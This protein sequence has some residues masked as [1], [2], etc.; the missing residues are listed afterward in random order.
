MPSFANW[1][2]EAI[3]PAYEDSRTLTGRT[4][5]VD[6][7]TDIF[8]FG[9]VLYEMLTGKRCFDGD[10]VSDILSAVLRVEPDWTRLP[11]G[12][13]SNVRNLLRLC[14]EK[15]AKNRRSDAT[16]VR[17]DIELALK[18]PTVTE[19]GSTPLLGRSSKAGWI[20]ATVVALALLSL[21]AVHFQEKPPAEPPE[22]RVDIT[23]P[24]TFL[25]LQF[26]LSP[27]GRSIVFVASGD[28]A[29]RLWL[30]RLDYA[31]AQALT[32][33]EGGQ[34]PFWS[35][36]GKSIAFFADAKLKRV[37]LAGGAPTVLTDA[38]P[39][40]G[41][42]NADG[43]ILFRTTLAPAISRINAGSGG[44]PATVTQVQG[45]GNLRSPHFL[46]DGKHF[47]F[48]V[49]AVANV[50]GLYLG[51]L[52]GGVPKRLG[53]A[54]SP[55]VPLPP[56]RILYIQQGKLL[57]RRL[58]L[59]RGELIGDPETV[60]D[61]VGT[62]GNNIGGFSV[63]ADGR[64]AY[65]SG[66]SGSSQLTWLDRSGK[67][68]GKPLDPDTNS[69]VAA[70][71]SPDGRRVAVDR[72]VQSNRDV[73]LIDLLRGGMT[74]FTFDAATD[75]YPVWSAD[76]IQIAFESSRKGNFDIYIKPS[77]G[78]GLEQPL[79]EAPGSQW[80]NDF[81]KDGKFLLYFDAS[82]SG[83]LMVLP[84][85]GAN[86]GPAGRSNQDSTGNERKPIPVATTTFVERT[87]A[88]SPDGRWVAYDTNESGKFEVVVQAF[89][90][91]NGKWQVSTGGG[92]Y[93]RWRADGKEL[94]FVADGKLMAAA[95]HVSGTSIDA[96]T[97]TPLFPLRINNSATGRQQ[98]AVSRDGRFLVNQ[99]TE[100][101]TVTPIT[102]IL[103]W[104]PK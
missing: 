3:N 55:A 58:D 17:L 98:Y 25:A 15:N 70:E 104:R 19:S 100:A 6:K 60:A 82:N 67:P 21:A 68:A 47:L 8:A 5:N 93:P 61:D 48:Y 97:P 42:W 91:P 65:R 103:N 16:D 62:D 89:P 69:L 75:G 41:A 66:G 63:S 24:A 18:E 92:E 31:E 37:D 46:P 83:D 85:S 72:T 84:M 30:R 38:A 88:F 9:A 50:Q 53:P 102:L 12:L 51:S 40:G 14:L 29:Q 57:V 26:A 1:H 74:R 13:P 45:V 49:Q 73:W 95:I 20:A 10:D 27:D 22:M 33:T 80:P 35:P 59:G 87:G 2:A 86:E 81:S 23:T 101:S 39:V 64:V 36:D 34:Y 11:A 71:I 28:G 96:A 32:G 52:D 76:G 7:R 54:D 56:D 78:S 79:L 90:N 94:Y 44:Q 4:R 77:N 43:V 99:Q